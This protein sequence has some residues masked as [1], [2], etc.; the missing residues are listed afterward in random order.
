MD[1]NV[2]LMNISN[3]IAIKGSMDG[4]RTLLQVVSKSPNTSSSSPNEYI[5][6]A[7]L[8]GFKNGSQTPSSLAADHINNTDHTLVASF[9][10]D[11]HTFFIG[12]GRAM[13]SYKSE[14]PHTELRLTRVTNSDSSENFE[15]RIDIVLSCIDMSEASTYQPMAAA[16]TD[17]GK[18][19]LIAMQNGNVESCICEFQLKK[20]NEAFESTKNIPLSNFGVTYGKIV[21]RLK[22][23]SVRALAESPE[24]RAFFVAF[25]EGNGSNERW[26]VERVRRNSMVGE[27]LWAVLANPNSGSLL[28]NNKVKTLIFADSNE[29]CSRYKLYN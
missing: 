21:G 20:L 13:I 2:Y 12:S 18:R 8:F 10:T 19:L 29:V 26:L 25:S 11:T 14:S 27:T 17:D 4:D 24:G 28:V 1:C 23:G 5:S 9:K 3:P 22:P 6:S 16:H 15:S 7:T